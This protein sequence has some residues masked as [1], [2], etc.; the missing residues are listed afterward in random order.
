[1]NCPN[2][3]QAMAAETL[4][5]HVGTSITIDICHPCQAIWF[6]DRE[7]LQLSPASTLRLFRVI[8]EATATERRALG[9]TLTCPRCAQHLKPV[10]DLQRTT[11]FHY[12]RCAKGHGRFITFFDFLKEKNFIKPMTAAEIAELRRNVATVNCSNCGA[13]ID[14]DHR[15]SCD[16]CG[17]V[18]SILD[19][20]QAEKLVGELRAADRS[21]Q[22]VDPALPLRL[23]HARR[24]LTASFDAFEHQS[25]WREHAS[26]S[27]LVLAGLRSLAKW[28][29]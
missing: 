18:L 2:C 24:E 5:G 12:R 28:L 1:V 16:H 23:E 14:L 26:S 4:A 19:T 15:S 7:S 17:S 13:A 25:S 29:G 20:A 9:A 3:S 10:S 22:P 21:N 6:D 8:G 11:R 27:G